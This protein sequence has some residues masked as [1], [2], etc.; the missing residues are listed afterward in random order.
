MDNVEKIKR[1]LA[2]PIQITLKNETGQEDIF[3]FKPLNVE[4]QAILMEISKRINDRKKIK[5]D[6]VEVPDVN[7]EDM[8]S[9]Y[10]LILDIARG[11]LGEID[12]QTL[13]N[14]VNNN[15]NQLS[16]KLEILVP[17]SG[18]SAL[19]K[20]KKKQE[21]LRNARKPVGKPQE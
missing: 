8:T 4:Q 9:M 11:S 2:K 10:E 18:S 7:K 19:E 12:E 3:D 17:K 6:G 16:D 1:H 21:E 13:V 14:F 20:I 15:F 5:I